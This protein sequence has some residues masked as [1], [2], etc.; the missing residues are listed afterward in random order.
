MFLRSQC[1]MFLRSLCRVRVFYLICSYSY[2]LLVL[3]DADDVHFPEVIARAANPRRGVP[4]LFE[5]QLREVVEGATTYVREQILQNRELN[6]EVIR[7]WWWLY[8]KP[9]HTL[10]TLFEL[11]GMHFF[12]SVYYE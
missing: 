11:D 7:T 4:E 2:V 12:Q 9:L 10:Q 8:I 5:E 6:E 3:Q 1:Y